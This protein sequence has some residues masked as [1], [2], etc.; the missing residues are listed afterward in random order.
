MRHRPLIDRILAK[1]QKRFQVRVY[2]KGVVSNHIHLAVR[3][4]SRIGLQNFFRVVAGQIAQ[5]ILKQFPLLPGERSRAGGAH[6]NG[7][8]PHREKE[9]KF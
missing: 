5:D 4:K 8:G 9:N 6:Q 1:A 7:K 3:G 2:E